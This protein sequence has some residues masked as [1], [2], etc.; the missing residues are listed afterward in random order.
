MVLVQTALAL[1]A[2]Y[3]AISYVGVVTF[4]LRN[5][6]ELPWEDMVVLDRSSGRYALC[7]VTA[8]G[9]LALTLR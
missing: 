7:A 4:A 9:F 6:D 3:A 8:A 1:A 2:I 5:R